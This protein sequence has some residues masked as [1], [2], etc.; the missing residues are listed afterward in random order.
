MKNN[1]KTIII[2]L[3]IVL[4]L[5]GVGVSSYNTMVT[6]KENVT[7][8]LSDIDVQLQRRADLIPNLVNT[9]KGYMKHEDKIINEITTAR[10]NLVNAKTTNEKSE[11]NSK[12][13]TAI[14]DLYVIVENYPD[15]K[16]NTTF[17]GLQDELAGSENRIAVARKNYNE[18]ATD[19]NTLI[20]KFPQS[21]VA[22][23]FKFET[24]SY[25]EAEEGAK[26]VPSVNFES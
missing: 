3:V 4:L 22:S 23:M 21:I 24:V 25:F 1:F 11:A 19:Y 12:L 16:A 9:V 15:L 5:G 20:K 17:I 6:K 2:I 7:T 14:N 10:T 8:K 18:A 13:T 26:N